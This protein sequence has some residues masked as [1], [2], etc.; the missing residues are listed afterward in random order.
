MAGEKAKVGELGAYSP[1]PSHLM[2]SKHVLNAQLS[3][4][5]SEHKGKR[6]RSLPWRCKRHTS[7]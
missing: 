4:W 5:Q 3:A 6:M 1:S 7:K 2:S